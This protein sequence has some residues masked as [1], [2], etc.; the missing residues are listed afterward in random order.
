MAP[1][2]TITR[3]A[4]GYLWSVGLILGVTA[5]AKVHSLWV[6]RGDFY[7]FDPLITFSRQGWLMAGAAALEV[8]VLIL[9][10]TLRDLPTRLGIILWLASVFALYR[11]G[12]WV[13]GYA[14]N[15]ACLG[16]PQSWWFTANSNLVEGLMRGSLFYLAV[17]SAVFW[18]LMSRR[19]VPLDRV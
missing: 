2:S 16:R 8:L 17:G 1:P 11:L 7:A 6:S 9:I 14:G 18:L 4:Q 12:L 3:I 19:R 5:L 10:L 15:C 13:V